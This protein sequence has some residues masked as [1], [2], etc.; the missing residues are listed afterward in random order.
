MI[1]LIAM[2]M[3]G[4]L[5]KSDNTIDDETKAFLLNLEEKGI[6]LVLASG[7]SYMKLMS[8]AKELKMD[9]YGGYLLEINGLAQNDVQHQKR[10]V[11]KQMSFEDVQD[12]CA[13]SKPF[14]I[15]MQALF[16]DGMFIDI[17]EKDMADK[18]AYRK[19]NHIPDDFP[20]TRGA[21]TF[22]HDN[23]PGY[24][25]Q[26]YIKDSKEINVA[27]NKMC[28]VADKEV[29]DEYC[30]K[31]RE[32]FKERFWMGKTTET[33]LEIMPAGINKGDALLE[34]A[35]QLGIQKDEILAFGDGEN[36]IEM[37]S[38]IPHGYAMGNGLESVKKIAPHVADTNMNQGILK[39]LKKY[40]A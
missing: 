35:K 17:P 34:L 27:I 21:L 10:V 25:K 39:V 16:D 4:T 33:W 22:M 6:R 40:F 9:Q 12:I 7:R 37:L 36:D 2:D 18:I 31:L 38:S 24:P 32:H 13:F 3:D 30:D 26:F 19:V 29:I 1:K 15:E 23:R 14:E 28:Y 11:K 5:L 8:Y 20:W